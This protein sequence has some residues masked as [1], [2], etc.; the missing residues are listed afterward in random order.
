MRTFYV[1]GHQWHMIFVEPWDPVLVD[2][3]GEMRVATTDPI[4]NCV[5]LSKELSGDFLRHVVAHELGHVFM[6]SYGVLAQLHGMSKPK[7]WIDIEE[8]IC[9]LIADHASAIST[10]T[11]DLIGD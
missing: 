9:N 10:M 1:N 7:Y 3:T 5:Y 8:W 2:R 11:S 6:L 4:T